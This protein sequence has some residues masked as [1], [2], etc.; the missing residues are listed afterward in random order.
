MFQYVGEICRYLLNQPKVPNVWA[1][2]L[3]RHG[4]VRFCELY[5]ATEG[6]VGFANVD[7]KLR[8]CGRDLPFLRLLIKYAL[9]KNDHEKDGPVRDD[10]GFCIP[11]PRGQPGLLVAPISKHMPFDGYL[12]NAEFTQRK[13]LHNVFMHGDRYFNSG[14]IMRIDK[15]GFIYFI[16]RV[17]DTFR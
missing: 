10:K 6:N 14:D 2:F 5:G 3:E 4:D 13:V 9:V 17:G 8:A 12:G 1:R 11:L 16:D 7:G 15:E